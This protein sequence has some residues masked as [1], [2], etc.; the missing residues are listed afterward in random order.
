MIKLTSHSTWPVLTPLNSA[1][2]GSQSAFGVALGIA[3]ES[4]RYGFDIGT[5]PLGFRY[6]DINTGGYLKLPLTQRTT[7][8]LSA[9]RRPVT[10]SLLSYAG[11]RDDRFSLVDVEWGGV[12]ASGGRAELGWSDGSFGIYGYGGYS[13]LTGH[14]V[15]RNNKWEG[16]GGFYMKLIDSDTQRF[17]SGI[18]FTSMGY[19][20][21]LR[22][23]TFG[24]GGYFSP[25][26]YF[27]V[28]VPLALEGRNGRLA[29][30]VRGALGVQSFR[31]DDAPYFPTN[32]TLQELA[33]QTMRLANSANLTSQTSA[34]Y[35]GQSKTGLAYNL[36]GS[37]EYQAAQQLYVGGLVGIDNARDY[38]QW[39]A[40]MYVRYALQRQTGQI[41]F[42]ASPPRSAVGPLPF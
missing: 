42:P 36:V 15:A 18:N 3:Y 34:V 2:A 37:L 13:V 5:T 20:E 12:M 14:D 33:N 4:E 16:G 17:T 32:G 22:Y 23:F 1:S 7:L 26:T 9:S 24:H 28:T 41:G 31:E 29:Y 25:Q 30:H 21:N 8:G 19:S 6:T 10:D 40:G 11:A 39:Y 38:R 35:A 27:A